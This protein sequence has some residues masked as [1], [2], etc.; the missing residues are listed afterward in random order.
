MARVAAPEDA[1]LLQDVRLVEDV[2][3]VEPQ[4]QRDVAE[5]ELLFGPQIQDVDVRITESVR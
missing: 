5:G 3:D 2:E 1:L 4:V